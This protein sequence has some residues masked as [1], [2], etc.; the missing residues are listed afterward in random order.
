MYSNSQKDKRIWIFKAKLNKRHFLELH[1]P[2][3]ILGYTADCT[4]RQL[5]LESK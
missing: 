4:I 2:I 3:P 5:K 1:L